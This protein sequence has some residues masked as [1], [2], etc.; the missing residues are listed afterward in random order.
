MPV[1]SAGRLLPLTTSD[2]NALLVWL[3]T[4]GSTFLIGI[5][6]SNFR[7]DHQVYLFQDRRALDPDEPIS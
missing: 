6:R 2:A 5:L 3:Q 4:Y 7:W 1:A